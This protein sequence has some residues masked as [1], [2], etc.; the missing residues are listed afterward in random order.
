[1]PLWFLQGKSEPKV[2]TQVLPPK[3]HER[4]S[5]GLNHWAFDRDGE[6]GWGLQKPVLRS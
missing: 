5:V 2:E 4:K 3:N 6:R 1:M